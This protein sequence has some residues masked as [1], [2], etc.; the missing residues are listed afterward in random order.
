MLKLKRLKD[1]SLPRVREAIEYMLQ[2][3]LNQWIYPRRMMVYMWSLTAYVTEE[4]VRSLMEDIY[5]E[6]L[7][8]PWKTYVKDEKGMC[9]KCAAFT[10][11]F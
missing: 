8:T 3:K 5:L 7:D 1:T 11:S 4:E 10:S 9:Y 2:Y 6:S